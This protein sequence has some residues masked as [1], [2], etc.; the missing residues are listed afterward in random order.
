MAFVHD[1]PY[2]MKEVRCAVCAVDETKHLNPKELSP[3]DRQ[4]LAALH[5]PGLRAQFFASRR[6]LKA[7]LPLGTLDQ[8]AFPSKKPEHPQ[9]QISLSHSK[10][11]GAAIY[12]PHL[13][14]GID[15][16]ELRSEVVKLRAR[17]VRPDEH[18]LV[19]ERAPQEGLQRIWG[20]KESLYKL[21]GRPGTHFLDHLEIASLEARGPWHVGMAWVHLPG[22]AD[23]ASREKPV[24][25]MARC[26]PNGPTLCIAS[27]RPPVQPMK[28]PRLTLRE[29][30]TNDA[31]F[32]FQLNN[33]AEVLRYTGDAPFASQTAALAFIKSYANYQ[34]DGFGRWLVEDKSTK[35]PL[36]WCGLKK[37]HWGVD[38]GFRFSR[39][40][41]GQ[42][43]ATEAAREAIAFARKQGLTRL[44][45]RAD[46]DNAASLRVLEKLGFVEEKTAE[47]RAAMSD[48]SPR[49]AECLRLFSL[50]LS[51]AV[52]A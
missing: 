52:H 35:E 22:D 37:H 5:A 24:L 48:L 40:S 36:G 44:Y 3:A 27:H 29:W 6:A 51:T 26:E 50:N 13:E 25:V 10:S 38:L 17:F 8:T 16:E 14:V 33:D 21:Q 32:L 15:Y 45:A 43:K 39:A 28:T 42:G 12:S 18:H 47:L 49:E 41:W 2:L 9:G 1:L 7:V 31:A 23:G 46:R 34:A 30:D 19:D 11:S 20:I 4:K